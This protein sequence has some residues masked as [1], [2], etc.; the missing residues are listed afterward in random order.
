MQCPKCGEPN[1]P[2]ESRCVSCGASL[3]VA[4]LEVVRGDLAEK[5]R[6]LRPRSHTIGR[7]RHNDIA[8][9]EPSIS[10]VHARLEYEAGRF[11]LED[12]DSRHGVYVNA[13]KVKRAE[14]VPGAQI[15]LGNV[16]LKFSLLGA[17][18]ATGA[19]GKLPWVE[20]QQL[21]LS[22]VQTLNAT[23]VLS[24][25]LE[26][27][28]DAVMQITGAERGFLLLADGSPD[29]AR[30]PAVTG[31]RLRVARAREGASSGAAEGQSISGSIVRRVMETGDTVA[32]TPGKD[33]R[34]T[35]DPEGAPH[36]VPCLPLRSPRA[37][38]DGAGSFPR[39]LGVIYVDNSGSAEA[40]SRDA[41]RAVEALARHAALAIEN[42]QLFERE[43]RTIEEL[44]RAQKQLLQSEKLA[45]IGQMAAGIAHELNTPLTY[46]MGNLELLALQ[47]ITPA[48]REMLEAVTRGADRIRTLAHR[49]LAFSRPGRE[50]MVALAP[51]DV[52]ERSL[53]LCQYQ[54][55]S[56][57]IQLVRKLAPDLPRVLGVS[58]QLEMAL[59]NLVI[60]AVHAMAEK[61]GILTV[62]SC[63]QGEEV[64]ITVSDEGPGV[65]EAVRESLFEPFVTTKPEGRGTGLGLSTVLMVVERHQGRIDFTTEEGR[66]TTFSL[67]LPVAA[68]A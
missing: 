25:V 27:V 45:T 3:S 2:S 29:A 63:R 57:R 49:L 9:N 44:K 55:S 14:L 16:T 42:A 52:V 24:Q 48:Q 22:L 34:S 61:G 6:F 18:S 17:E 46:I 50:E 54:I 32:S 53:E 5:I 56:G 8:L 51:N 64:L 1:P 66:G 65:P 43:Q 39:P 59:I 12:A 28:L 35:P 10:K 26:Q 21:L 62:G 30:F 13:A 33:L 37:G 31:L 4:V 68:A 11:T 36:T 7:A 38:A 41:L 58:N 60:N 19:M 67:R 40:F 23:L 15:Q 20:Q 47:E